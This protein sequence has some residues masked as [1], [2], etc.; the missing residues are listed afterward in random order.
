LTPGS[1]S[2]RQVTRLSRAPLSIT[3]CAS[4]G[5][6]LEHSTSTSSRSS[7]R[8]Q[9][10]SQGASAEA[11]PCM[12]SQSSPC[13]HPSCCLKLCKTLSFPQT[14]PCAGPMCSAQR[15]TWPQHA[16]SILQPS[17]RSGFAVPGNTPA[18]WHTAQHRLSTET[19]LTASAMHMCSAQQREP[20]SVQAQ[21]QGCP[22]HPAVLLYVSAR[23]A[24]HPTHPSTHQLWQD[25]VLHHCLCQVIT[26]VCQAP[27]RQ[28][29]RL[30]YAAGRK[31]QRTAKGPSAREEAHHTNTERQR[32]NRSKQL[33]CA[34]C[35]NGACS[36]E[37]SSSTWPRCPA[38][39]DAA[40]P[41]RLPAAGPQCSAVC[42][43]HL[44]VC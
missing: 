26:V 9:H 6:C 10:K 17:C 41:S 34:R 22:S 27:Q 38:A 7:S 43:R 40:G 12:W 35:W 5:E 18:V 23:V 29:R 4:S 25:L 39:G 36:L 16:G 32:Q 2:S 21:Q 1:N 31:Q 19:A 11:G 14:L 13:C 30:L 24:C 44:N 20:M 3:A 15:L 8:C 37:C 33:C 42:R 28:G